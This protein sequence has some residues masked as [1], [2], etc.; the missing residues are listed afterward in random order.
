M[1]TKVGAQ[2]LKGHGL[3]GEQRE[4]PCG[5]SIKKDAG[6]QLGSVVRPNRGVFYRQQRDSVFVC[7]FSFLN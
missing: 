7:L 2:G 4:I 5:Q 6:K 1:G 3:C